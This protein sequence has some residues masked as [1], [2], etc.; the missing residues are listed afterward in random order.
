MFLCSIF[1]TDGQ[2]RST[3]GFP[4]LGPVLEVAQ[5]LDLELSSYS[6]RRWL[7]ECTG[8]HAQCNSADSN[9]LPTRVLDLGEGNGPIEVRLYETVTGQLDKYIALSYCWGKCGNLVTT[10]ATL[11]DRK[12]G[13]PWDSMPQTFRDAAEISRKLEIRYLWLD[14]LCIIQDDASDWER[15]AARTAEVYENAFVTIAVNSAFNPMQ[16]IFTARDTALISTSGSN[17]SSSVRHK[18]R[19]R[20]ASVEELTL[21]D[22]EGN[23]QYTIH[24][25]EPIAH[26]DVILPRS[27]YDITYPLMTRAWTLQER[28][29][30]RRTLHITA[31]ELLWECKDAMLCECGTVAQTIDNIAGTKTPKIDYE[32]AMRAIVD[33]NKALGDS[34]PASTTA[35]GSAHL[36][37]LTPRTTKEWTLLIGGYSNHQLSFESDRLP[38]ISAL[39][40][41]FS[42]VDKL[43]RR[44]RAYLAGLWLIDLPWQLCWRAYDRRFETRPDAYCGST[45]SWVATRTPVIWDSKIYNAQSQV[46]V[47]RAAAQLQGRSNVFGQVK[48]ASATVQGCVQSATVNFEAAHHEA[49]LGL[50]NRRG[51]RIFFVPDQDPERA[52]DATLRDQSLL[53]TSQVSQR[54]VSTLQDGETVICLWLLHHLK[55]NEVY[56]LVLATPSH[57]SILRSMPESELGTMS[58][59][60][61][62]RVGAITGMS[63]VYQKNE[64][65]GPSWFEDG[66]TQT[67]T[68]I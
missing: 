46:R 62:E 18:R 21:Y 30:S 49:V 16:G 25:R 39:T 4:I 51:E 37:P 42:L 36:S 41:R 45:W 61:Y 28:I 40:R 32:I 11:K 6:V 26:Q 17:T 48:S 50:R 54:M 9:W 35:A 60:V 29:L 68:I 58:S 56:G 7:A 19:K 43:P 66:E 63:H 14:A 65:S 1:F 33:E 5:Y 24:A 15:E 55:S 47:V 23:P 8:S 44:P 57:E 53:G 64:V 2:V 59:S 12:E 22:E 3:K 27:Y 52:G 31:A 34:E 10:K 20:S 67:V 38:A 13:I